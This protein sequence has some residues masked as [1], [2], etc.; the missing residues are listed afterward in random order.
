MADAFTIAIGIPF[1]G[2]GKCRAFSNFLYKTLLG[3]NE[4]FLDFNILKL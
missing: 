3:K 2:N 1:L 4:D